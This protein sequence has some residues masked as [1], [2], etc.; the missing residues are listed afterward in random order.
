MVCYFCYYE[1]FLE[2][3]VDR[4]PCKPGKRYYHTASLVDNNIYYFG[5]KDFS[6]RINELYKYNGTTGKL[7]GA[8]GINYF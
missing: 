8:S 6:V 4:E 1:F 7:I 2:L 5:G 3:K